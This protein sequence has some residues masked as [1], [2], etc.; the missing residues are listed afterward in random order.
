MSKY[1]KSSD[2]DKQRVNILTGGK[3]KQHI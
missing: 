3:N 1:K 2:E